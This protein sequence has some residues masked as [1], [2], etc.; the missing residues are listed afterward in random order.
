MRTDICYCNSNPEYCFFDY[1]QRWI[2]KSLSEQV[3]RDIRA[4]RKC[5]GVWK[6]STID[7]RSAFCTMSY[8]NKL[9]E[10]DNEMK[11]TLDKLPNG[12]YNVK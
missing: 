9:Y 5:S 12:Y 4:D 10:C 2:C 1:L 11:E 7:I 3:G 8:T 6:S